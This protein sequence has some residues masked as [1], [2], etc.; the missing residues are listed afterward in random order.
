MPKEAEGDCVPGGH[1]P[2]SLVTTVNRPGARRAHKAISPQLAQLLSGVDAATRSRLEARLMR[3]VNACGCPSGA[4]A[5]VLGSVLS[6]L[7]WLTERDGRLI[8]GREAGIAALAVVTATALAKLGGILVARLW[9]AWIQR[10][11]ER[12]LEHPSLKS[13]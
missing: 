6:V 13:T 7:W 5:L 3:A 1:T 10:R 11:L 4:F 12:R 2:E 9:V 8:M